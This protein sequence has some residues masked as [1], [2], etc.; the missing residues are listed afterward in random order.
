[1]QHQVRVDAGDAEAEEAGARLEPELRRLLLGGD[2]HGGRAVDDLRR[3]PAV[4]TPSGMNAGWSCA[5]FSSVV[6]RIASSTAKRVRV[7]VARAAAVAAGDRHVDLDRDDL[8]VEAP[9]VDRARAARTCDSRS[10]WSSS[11]RESFHFFAISSAEMPCMTMSK[12]SVTR[13]DIEPWFEPIGTRDIISTPPEMTRS[14]CPDQ[15]AAAALKFVCIEEPHWRSTVVPHTETGQPAV[16]ATLRPMFHACSSTWVTQ[17]HCRS[18]I[19]AGIDVVPRD[20]PV[21]DLGRQL[22]AADVRE[23]AVLLADRAADGVDDERV[24]TSRHDNTVS[25]GA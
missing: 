24:G 20:E 14:S 23:R 13:S 25:R 8:L 9:L 15:T 10:S 5:I 11:S 21:H 19:C 16:S 6:S 2:E 4:T 7:S 22:V 18:S 12:R 3:V 1:M 17:P